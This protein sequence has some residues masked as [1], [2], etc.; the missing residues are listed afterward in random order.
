MVLVGDINEAA[1]EAGCNGL[2]RSARNLGSSGRIRRPAITWQN[3]MIG[4]LAPGRSSP[5]NLSAA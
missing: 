4:V 1:A 3:Q 5:S 2:P